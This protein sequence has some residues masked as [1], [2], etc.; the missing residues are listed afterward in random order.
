MTDET[1]TYKYDRDLIHIPRLIKPYIYNT[2][3]KKAF[4]TT[5]NAHI[6]LI[7]ACLSF[8]FIL[9]SYYTQNGKSFKEH[10]YDGGYKVTLAG[11]GNITC[12]VLHLDKKKIPPGNN[13]EARSFYL[14]IKGDVPKDAFVRI[15]NVQALATTFAKIYKLNDANEIIAFNRQRNKSLN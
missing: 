15:D 2:S 5:L 11:V 8:P 10:G 1:L 6:T 13:L 3:D 4:L 9:D 12:T 14:S 7:K